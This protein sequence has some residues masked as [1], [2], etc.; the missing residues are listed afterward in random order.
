MSAPRLRSLRA[1]ALALGGCASGCLPVDTRPPPA[2][3]LVTVSGSAGVRSGIP[4]A[5]M[6]DGWSVTFDRF[7]VAIGESSLE[8]DSCTPYSDAGY[9]RVIDAQQPAPQKLSQLFG[10]GTCGVSFQVRNPEQGTLLGVGVT[11]QELALMLTP[12]GDAY[13]PSSGISMLVRGRATKGAS[14]KTFSWT[15]RTPRLSYVDCAPT[16]G[17]DP[18]VLTLVGSE[19]LTLGVELHGEAL[20]QDQLDPA[21]AKLWFGPF[22]DADDKTGNA[23]G[24]VTLDELGN[25]TLESLGVSPA[26]PPTGDAGVPTWTTFEDFVYLGLFPQI[27]RLTGGGACTVTAGRRRG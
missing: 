27:P 20:F 14:T 18:L 10:L 7:L 19:A 22:A 3:V 13:A 11:E 5:S 1:L 21:K 25:V 12:G 8:R 6:S 24:E 16:P 9:R 15:F 2:T 4:S 17:A 23:D 26:A